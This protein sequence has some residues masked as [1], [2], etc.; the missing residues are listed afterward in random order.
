MAVERAKAENEER[1]RRREDMTELQDILNRNSKALLD[2]NTNRRVQAKWARY[3]RCDGSPDPTIQG[4]INTYINL[5]LEDNSRDDAI[6][7]LKD[8]L[9]DLSLIEELRFLLEDTPTEELSENERSLYKE[10][11]KEL[12]KLLD[13]KL[14][15]AT[16][17]I[18]C[19][20]T[21]LSNP[22]TNNLEHVVKN[23]PISLCVWG[24]ITKNKRINKFSFGE[25]NVTFDI[26]KA[27]ALMDCG[28]RVL[29]TKFDHLSPT[30]KAALPRRKK[31]EE[32]VPE[33]TEEEKKESEEGEKAEGEE[34]A[35]EDGEKKEGD[36]EDKEKEETDIDLMAALRGDDEGEKEEEEVEEIMEDDFEDPTTPE[37]TEWEDFDEEDDIIDLRANDVLGGVF[38]VNLLQ[39]PPQPKTAGAWTITQL[40]T[41]AEITKLDYTPDPP[42]PEAEKGKDKEKEKDL[43]PPIGISMILPNDVLFLEEPQI[44][45]WDYAKKLWSTKDISDVAYNEDTRSVTFK[46]NCFGS[47]CLLQDSHINMPFQSWEIRPHKLNSAVLSIIAAIVE[48]EIEIK[49]ALCC[50]TQPHDKPEL[51]SIRGKWVTPTELISMMKN[52]GVNV[53]PQ[54]DSSKYVS[55]QNKETGEP[56]EWKHPLIEDRVYQQMALTASAM[57]YSWSKWNGETDKDQVVFQAAESLEDEPLL[58]EDWWVFC[59]TKRRVTK[60][61]MTEFD[62]AFS[63]EPDGDKDQF[64]DKASKHLLPSG[65]E[66]PNSTLR[67]V[68]TGSTL[69]NGSKS[70]PQ[71]PSVRSIASSQKPS[72][73]SLT[74]VSKKTKKQT[75]PMLKIEEAIVPA[76]LTYFNHKRSPFKCNIYHLMKDVCTEQAQARV[77]ETNFQFVDAVCQLLKATKVLTYA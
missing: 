66:R 53:F 19:D 35:E 60:L 57:A 36:E 20:A 51:E 75:T 67:N 76:F 5:K 16:L 17:Q 37:P 26:P 46:T 77:N 54:E 62:D 13:R 11:M 47:M 65:S 50:L 61:K 49:D 24:N 64:K 44:A 27:L 6:S 28:V 22:E 9:L 7:V 63:D 31:K 69:F 1:R 48:I 43:K 39:M 41:P 74:A 68:K 70:S 55:I 32:V 21:K 15:L 2:L 18:L 4:E 38:Q 8:S 23:D 30:S 34:G 45:H 56:R 42:I 59:A 10:T 58:E 52:A 25:V 12:E 40:V 14:D 71:S 3:M 73:S 72:L 33:I 29:I